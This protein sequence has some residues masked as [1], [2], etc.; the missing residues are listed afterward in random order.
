MAVIEV[1]AK[2][3]F[4]KSMGEDLRNIIRQNREVIDSNPKLKECKATTVLEQNCSYLHYMRE[5]GLKYYADRFDSMEA[6]CK[7]CDLNG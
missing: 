3:L 4:N 2:G 6:I 1:A 7:H 5:V